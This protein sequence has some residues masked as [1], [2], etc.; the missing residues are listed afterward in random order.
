MLTHS[1]FLVL[2]H[3]QVWENPCGTQIRGRPVRDVESFSSFE[4]PPPKGE[5]NR[6]LES[7]QL[8]Q[9]EREIILSEQKSL[10]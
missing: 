7:V 4:R 8:S 9:T 10:P 6:E 5:R 1:V 2:R 3:I